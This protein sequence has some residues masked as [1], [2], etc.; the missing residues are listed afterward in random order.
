MSAHDRLKADVR[1]ASVTRKRA[2]WAGGVL[3]ETICIS[4]AKNSMTRRLREAKAKATR[5]Y[6]A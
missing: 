6:V 4:G 1:L 2:T 5:N 3:A